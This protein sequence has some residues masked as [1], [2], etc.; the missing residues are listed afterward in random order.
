MLIAL[1]FKLVSGKL[2]NLLLIELLV[3][4]IQLVS[5]SSASYR[6]H[7]PISLRTRVCGSSGRAQS[8]SSGSFSDLIVPMRSTS[9]TWKQKGCRFDQGVLNLLTIN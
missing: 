2:V 8:R 4:A 3:R 5:F 1:H 9:S 6:D 7:T